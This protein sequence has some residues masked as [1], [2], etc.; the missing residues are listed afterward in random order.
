M[1]NAK[2]RELQD[3]LA[4]DFGKRFSDMKVD[5]LAELLCVDR[6]CIFIVF[7][8]THIKCDKILISKIRTLLREFNL[9]SE[10]EFA[11]FASEGDSRMAGTGY[12]FAVQCKAVERCRDR[13]KEIFFGIHLQTAEP[14]KLFN[15][16]EYLTF[17]S[18]V[19]K[20][21]GE[22]LEHTFVHGAGRFYRFLFDSRKLVINAGSLR[23]FLASLPQ[24]C[25]NHL[26]LSGPKASKGDWAFP[27][28]GY[29]IRGCD[30]TEHAKRSSHERLMKRAHE[31]IE[32][33]L[34]VHDPRTFACEAPVWIQPSD[35]VD[36]EAR[37]TTKSCITGHID[38]LR[39][40]E[41]GHIG[42]WDYKP[43]AG[44]EKTAA[45]QV[46]FYMMMLSKRARIPIDQIKGGYFDEVEAFSVRQK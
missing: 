44:K 8:G 10:K 16:S 23:E 20:K 24:N 34:M 35:F 15:L 45:Q 12:V 32:K 30:L 22:F 1:H 19:K 11:L 2:V 14:G 5:E 42:L 37:F 6:S 28:I 38:I 21:K 46:W 36:Y 41:N 4:F 27:V 18:P 40:E 25:P 43:G 3:H 33:Y 7:D 13:L 26:F 17:I 31:N 39:L 9:L 29:P